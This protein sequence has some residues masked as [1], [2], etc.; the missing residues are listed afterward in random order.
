MLQQ[1]E[2]PPHADFP[3][4]AVAG[5][6]A[7][8]ATQ[9]GGRY[10]VEPEALLLAIF[11]LVGSLVNRTVVGRCLFD[12]PLRPGIHSITTTHHPVQ[13]AAFERLLQPIFHEM[14]TADRYARESDAEERERRIRELHA[15]FTRAPAH[16]K[17]E[18]LT[19]LARWVLSWHTGPVC[20]A[21]SLAELEVILGRCRHPNL[22]LEGSSVDYPVVL[23]QTRLRDVRTLYQALARTFD[24]E[25]AEIHPGGGGVCACWTTGPQTLADSFALL[26]RNGM[27]AP[28]PFALFSCGANPRALAG[29]PA[30]SYPAEEAWGAYCR[31]LIQ[32]TVL[33]PADRS[34]EF[35]ADAREVLVA[36]HNELLGWDQPEAAHFVAIAQKLALIFAATGSDSD[37]PVETVGNAVAVTRWYAARH[38]ECLRSLPAA[39]YARR[40]S[41]AAER[42]E[43]EVMLDKIMARP[44]GITFRELCRS[45]HRGDG[46]RLRTLLDRLVAEGLV[47]RQGHRYVGGSA[48]RENAPTGGVVESAG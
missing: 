10:G 43:T 25:P 26:R 29:D 34:M 6:Y 9:V 24:G 38:L 48:G 37:I 45:Y 13:A 39:D 2:T 8:V 44:G 28:A 21:T 17:G 1:A 30:A 12:K 14:L 4:D 5:G 20:W 46:T 16:E 19:E 11:T 18:A 35:T 31:H 41:V 27:D 47:A 23:L 7:R 3:W 36:W 22:L 15:E 33:T 42:S 32:R 40:R